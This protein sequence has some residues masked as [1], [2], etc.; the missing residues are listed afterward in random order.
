MNLLKKLQTT[1]KMNMKK[2]TNETKALK[3]SYAFIPIFG[4][5]A[6]LCNMISVAYAAGIKTPSMDTLVKDIFKDVIFKLF[7]YGGIGCAAVALFSF[8]MADV[9]NDESGKNR[10]FVCTIGAIILVGLPALLK[11]WF[12]L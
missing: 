4:M 3:S 8:G 1:K 10:G 7:T 6:T 11:K 12:G 9:N 5:A 2:N